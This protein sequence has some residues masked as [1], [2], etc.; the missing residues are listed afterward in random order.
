[1]AISIFWY[2]MFWQVNDEVIKPESQQIVKDVTGHV[3]AKIINKHGKWAVEIPYKISGMIKDQKFMVYSNLRY[4]GMMSGLCGDY[5]E[6]KMYDFQG[7]KHCLYRDTELFMQSW[8]SEDTDCPKYADYQQ[9]VHQFQDGCHK[10]P[11]H[12]Y[13]PYITAEYKS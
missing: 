4:K 9:H 8:V 11:T 6:D 1:M 5:N 13:Q 2:N 10:A 3:F 12:N 7:P